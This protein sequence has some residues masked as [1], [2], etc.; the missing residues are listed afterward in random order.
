MVYGSDDYADLSQRAPIPRCCAT[1]FERMATFSRAPNERRYRYAWPQE[2]RTRRRIAHAFP[3]S[4]LYA[5]A[6]ADLIVRL[7]LPLHG[8]LGLRC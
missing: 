3:V 1:A 4:R 5:T 7:V 2:G 6:R 8:R